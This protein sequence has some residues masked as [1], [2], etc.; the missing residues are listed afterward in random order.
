[1]KAVTFKQKVDKLIAEANMPGLK[2]KFSFKQDK[3]FAE[4][5]D[6]TVIIASPSSNKVTVRWGSGHQAV[7]S[8]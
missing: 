8:I 6:G 4:C 2:A 7:A 1:M 5:S 3:F